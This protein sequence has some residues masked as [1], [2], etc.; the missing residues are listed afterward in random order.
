MY[1]FGH[2]Q[3]FYLGFV[4]LKIWPW[5]LVSS[6]DAFQEGLI[7]VT[8]FV[9][10]GI[11]F[12]LHVYKSV[13]PHIPLPVILSPYHSCLSHS[14]KAQH[15]HFQLS[16]SFL[17][18]YIPDQPTN[19]WPCLLLMAALYCWEFISGSLKLS[20][21]LTCWFQIDMKLCL[22]KADAKHSDVMN[23]YSVVTPLFV[24]TCVLPCRIF[25]YRN[26][27]ETQKHICIMKPVFF[28]LKHSRMVNT[29]GKQNLNLKCAFSKEVKCDAN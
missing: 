22:C 10:W 17:N 27:K 21:Y 13:L 18:L 14:Q 25:V 29:S 28:W 12:Q 16:C 15:F 8:Y 23:K 6:S 19:L 9:T 7:I 20:S 1:I 26:K 24:A 11:A 3:K 5:S 4:T 2:I